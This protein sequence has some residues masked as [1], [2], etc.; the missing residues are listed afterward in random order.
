[1][2]DFFQNGVITTIQDFRRRDYEDLDKKME[3]LSK[4]RNMALI[5]PALYSEFET[6]AMERIIEEL[7]GIS[8]LYKI[9]FGLDSATKEQFEHVKE[10]LSELPSRVISCGMTVTISHR[11]MTRFR[12]PVLPARTSGGREEMCGC[13]SGTS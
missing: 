2:G 10:I 6:P 12:L 7:K 8:Y 4:R 3:N 5:L 9:V 1:M 13:V 11:C